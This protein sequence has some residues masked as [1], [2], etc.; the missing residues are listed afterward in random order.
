MT[1]EVDGLVSV[2]ARQ[3]RHVRIA[4]GR[5]LCLTILVKIESWSMER[6]MGTRGGKG[7][8]AGGRSG[9]VSAKERVSV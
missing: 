4:F 9:G 2:F 6:G 8:S 5:I 7:M 1:A 3:P